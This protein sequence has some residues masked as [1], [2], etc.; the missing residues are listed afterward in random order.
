MRK[1]FSDS[2]IFFINSTWNEE[3]HRIHIGKHSF[4]LEILSRALAK[5]KK[6]G[7][8]GLLGLA[9]HPD[10]KRNNLVYFAY[11]AKRKG[12]Y[13]TEVARGVLRGMSMRPFSSAI[14]IHEYGP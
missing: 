11:T 12:S 14:W 13:G 7:Q 6:K 10:F 5:I 1:F 9:L 2:S 8:G 4:R 3:L